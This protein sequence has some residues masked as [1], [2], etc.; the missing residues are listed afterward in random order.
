VQGG[1]SQD[2]NL[3]QFFLNVLEFGMNVQEETEAPNFN[4]FQMKSSFGNR[5]SRPGRIILS[6]SALA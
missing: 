2:Q 3:L 5:E 6:E 4:S 1:D